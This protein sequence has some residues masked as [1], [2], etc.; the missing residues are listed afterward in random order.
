M[1]ADERSPAAPG[2]CSACGTD[3]ADQNAM[4]RRCGWDKA[5]LRRSCLRCG[6]AVEPKPDTSALKLPGSAALLIVGVSGFLGGFLGGFGVGCGMAAVGSVVMARTMRQ[7]CIVCGAFVPTGVLSP[8]ERQQLIDHRTR[9]YVR[10]GL[11]GAASLVAGGVWLAFTLHRAAPEQQAEM[12]APVSENAGRKPDVAALQAAR[13]T[14]ALARLVQNDAD[15]R[16]P[17]AKALGSLGPAG[18][19]ALDSLLRVEKSLV[20]RA[21]I[22][23]LSE[24]APEIDEAIPTLIGLVQTNERFVRYEAI[25]VLGKTGPRAAAAADPLRRL[26][27]DRDVGRAAKEALA[28]IEH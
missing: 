19:H 28:K 4:C 24:A 20:Q 26:I 7:R 25:K 8:G 3:L 1:T 18:V 27:G 9:L 13:D 15:A 6:E 10:A 17:A 16:Y 12:G 5:K 2:T 23:G 14:E 22:A 11:F 21:A